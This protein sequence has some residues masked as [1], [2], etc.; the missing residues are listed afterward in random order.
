MQPE[1]FIG[2][3]ILIVSIVLHE[4]AHGHAA[5]LL[6]D[7][8]ARL[9]G[10]LTLNPLKH[11]DPM[12]SVFIPLVLVFAHSPIFFGYAKPVPYNPYNLR[13][14]FGEPIVA[15][16]GPLT[17]IAL[18]LAAGIIIRVAGPLGADASFIEVM[19]LA[20]YVNL[21][22]ALFNLIPI[23][24]LDGSKVLGA[25]L[26]GGLSRSYDRLRERLEGYGMLFG[27]ALVLLV[28]FLFRGV[29]VWIVSALFTLFTGL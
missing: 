27:F 21:F 22:L 4:V 15:A 14:R 26:P 24:P 8:T 9:A 1:L 18:A 20:V 29:F 12:G 6:G 11:L 28:F 7:P 10:R 23:P 25:L 2:L 16:A 19:S 3:A 13:G 5:D 17:N